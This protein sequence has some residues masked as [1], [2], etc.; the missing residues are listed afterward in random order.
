MDPTPSSLLAVFL[1]LVGI[2]ILRAIYRFAEYAETMLAFRW[3]QNKGHP[4]CHDGCAKCLEY[5]QKLGIAAKLPQAIA[6]RCNQRHRYLLPATWEELP[7]PV[8]MVI[9]HYEMDGWAD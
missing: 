9:D 5:H 8:A 1:L 7:S 4:D 3:H 2:K 6:L